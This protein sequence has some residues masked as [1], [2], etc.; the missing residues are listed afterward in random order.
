[1]SEQ[2]KP[3]GKPQSPFD[4]VPETPAQPEE[5]KTVFAPMPIQTPP[6]EAE[7]PKKPRKSRAKT[8][9][10]PALQAEPVAAPPP[11]A[12][13]PRMTNFPPVAPRADAGQIQIGDVLNHIFEVRRFIARGGMGEV[14]EG[15]NVNSDERVAIKVMLPSLAA[16]PNVQAMFKKEARTLTRLSHPALVQYRVIAQEPQ[17]GVLYIV[18]EFVDSKNLQDALPSLRPTAQQ[19]LALTRRLADGLRVAH[20][21]GAIHRDISPDNI[22]LEDGELSKARIIDFGI[23]KDLDPSS[24]TIIGDGFAGK[25]NYV[26]PEQLGDFNREVGPWTDLY[27]L[28]L[29]IL[30]VAQGR[31]VD[32]GA[33]LVDAVDKRRQGPDLSTA[34][35]EIRPLL[36][37]MLKPNPVERLRSM[38]EVIAMIDGMTGAKT[39]PVQQ[40]SAT[41]P[42]PQSRPAGAPAAAKPGLDPKTLMIGGGV[43]GIIAI[44]IAGVLIFGGKGDKA[45][46]QTQMTAAQAID[47]ARQTINATLPSAQC[48]WLDI[49]TVSGGVSGI[50]LSIKGVARDT[51]AVQKLVSDA[52]AAKGLTLANLDTN[53]VAPLTR[54][55]ACPLLTEYNSIKSETTTLGSPQVKWEMSVPPDSTD[56]KPMAKTIVNFRVDPGTQDFA[57]FGLQN[58]GDGIALIQSLGQLQDAS[59]RQGYGIADLG[60]G[61][62]EMGLD[63]SE[64]GWA[65]I[66]IVRGSGPIE[67]GTILP[68][69]AQRTP[70]WEQQFN[71]IAASKGWH[72]EMIWMNT[73]D[74]VP[75]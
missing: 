52:I 56:G 50:N 64:T 45:P 47:T 27:S 23:A 38:D 40:G 36:T 5:Q 68:P 74:E 4:M 19:L 18:T 49:D 28:G 20:S 34:P 61:R 9:F 30:S 6:A 73:V 31:G 67:A 11:P 1:M 51:A 58:S 37:A 71:Q 41:P 8:Q 69:A 44:A 53:G 3:D 57:M 22:L 10:A 33:T 17:L 25:L 59:F 7:E 60:G 32:M 63:Q 26:A 42:P 21:L 62:Y 24:K 46:A 12:S 66:L 39:Q 15:V 35:E 75:N 48:A 70:Q 54:Q 29:V 43:A 72:T 14:F 2:D 55:D 65:G 16:D 13:E